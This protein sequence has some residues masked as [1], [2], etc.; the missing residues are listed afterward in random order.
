MP[1][2]EFKAKTIDKALKDIEKDL[3]AKISALKSVYDDEVEKWE[4]EVE[5]L[6]KEVQTLTEGLSEQQYEQVL[7]LICELKEQ[8]AAAKVEDDDIERPS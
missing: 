8:N 7:K 1:T 6:K 3:K 4:R 5:K 2:A